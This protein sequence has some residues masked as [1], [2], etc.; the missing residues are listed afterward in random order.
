VIQKLKEIQKSFKSSAELKNCKELAIT[1]NMK[2]S[3]Q[4]F[5]ASFE[6]KTKLSV[7]FTKPSKN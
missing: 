4:V 2:L 7:G 6:K 1:S 5:Y 3:I